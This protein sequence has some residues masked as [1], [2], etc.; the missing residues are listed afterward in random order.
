[1]VMRPN[2]LQ[3]N[4]LESTGGEPTGCRHPLQSG[5]E[6]PSRFTFPFCYEPHALCVEAA[7]AVQRHLREHFLELQQQEGKMFGVLVVRQEE[8]ENSA[9]SDS[10]ETSECSEFSEFSELSEKPALPAKSPLFFLAAYSGLLEGR[11]D[12]PWFVPSVFD[13]QQPDGHFKQEEARISAINRQIAALE[14]DP[15]RLRLKAETERLRKQA[16]L[17][18]GQYKATMAAAKALRDR[19]RQQAAPLTEAE[20]AAMVHESQFQKAELRRLKKQLSLS[21]Q[22]AEDQ[23]QAFDQRI[24]ELQRE[25]R[26]RSEALQQWLFSQYDMLNAR[27]QRRNLCSI[28]SQTPQGTPPAGAGDC[29]APKL[30]QYA[31][32]HRLQPVAMAEFWWGRSPKSEIRHQ[33]NFYPACRGKCLPILGH[34]LEG[35]EVD[36]NPLE[37]ACS[38]GFR[39]LFEND[40]MAAVCK[41]SGLQSVPGRTGAASVESIMRMRCPEAPCIKA[42]HRLDMATS[43]VMLV[44]KTLGAY[45]DLQQQF[46][47][48]KVRKVYV[49][50][51]EGTANRPRQGI[52]S[53]PLRPDV[54][55]RPRQV[56]DL[57]RGKEA[58]T[59]YEIVGQEGGQTLVRLFPQTGRT[60][61]LRVHCAHP[62]GLG[63]PI[64]GDPL[65]GHAG[66]RLM[67]HAQ[68][69][70]FTP[71][72]SQNEMTIHC[73][74]TFF[75]GPEKH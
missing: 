30:L 40:L 1:M 11:N 20:A 65:Y 7:E 28:F 74:P 5:A 34:M 39:V 69:I 46:L 38:E 48:H 55:D 57:K 9:F 67:L 31:Y 66:G 25:R 63:C 61:Q 43:G 50:R 22:A 21:V 44:A 24:A 15:E 75:L 47:R 37:Q 70:T 29:C 56:V 12:W 3:N 23:L 45:H 72:H 32:E 35:L 52:I 41:P 54:L 18:I 53:L 4:F 6:P 51:L 62:D 16:E 33:G 17:E 10:P 14:T 59:R 68:D 26:E 64:V 42:V 49:A 60:H 71:P 8:S 36:P 2:M 13:A 19:R 58:I 73:E 27:G